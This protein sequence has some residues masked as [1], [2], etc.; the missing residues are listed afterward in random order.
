M[1][2]VTPF[3]ES[4]RDLQSLRI[5]E[6][7]RKP[8]GKG[9]WQLLVLIVTA[10]I[11]TSAWSV[12]RSM[13]QSKTAVETFVV[14]GLQIQGDHLASLNASGYVTPRRRATIAS[15]TT[16]RLSGVYVDEGTIVTQGQIIA[17]LDDS[18][19]VHSLTVLKEDRDT[20]ITAIKDYE[21]QLRQADI[22]LRRTE[23]LVTAGISPQQDLDSAVAA[24]NSIN[25][26]VTV[27]KQQVQAAEARVAEA[28]QTLADS[29]IY[30]PF[31][32]VVV[33]R[34]A[35]VGEMVSPVSA[36][37]GFTRTGIATLVD[38]S[39]LEVEVDVNESYIARVSVNQPVFAILDAYPDI[40]FPGKVRA[41][42]PTA[43]RQKATVKVRVSFLKLDPRILPDMGVKVGFL[44]EGAAHETGKHINLAH[45][46]IPSA[47]IHHE[48]EANLV[49]LVNGGRAE[50]RAVSVG[51]SAEDNTEILAGLTTGDTIIVR[52]SGPV[53]DGQQV[54]VKR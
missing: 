14:A 17:R 48:G 40:R 54:T 38:M 49:Y 42:I 50:R 47:A 35:Q 25:A 15:K 20:S 8:G 16:G 21:V 12:T 51:R 4:V 7:K 2:A 6:G 39:S 37:G 3:K 11:L 28:Q 46:L 26:K 18:N 33:S 5:P 44:D 52:S 1:P 45:A 22:V 24:D 32:G 29:I 9:K 31:G 23:Q 53:R 10:V 41:I 13:F 34:D 27:A 43:D 36:G 19:L 30:A